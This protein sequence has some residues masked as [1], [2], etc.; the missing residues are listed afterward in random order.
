[1]NTF[2]LDEVKRDILQF[3]WNLLLILLSAFLP[4]VY[5]P[6]SHCSNPKLVIFYCFMYN[7]I[8]G[9]FDWKEKRYS[10]IGMCCIWISFSFSE[11]IVVFVKACSFLKGALHTCMYTECSFPY[12]GW[13]L[14]ENCSQKFCNCENKW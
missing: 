8:F 14:L 12:I 10:K 6:Y 2:L 7:E 5:W 4:T 1:M 9:R 3:R 13:S 11:F